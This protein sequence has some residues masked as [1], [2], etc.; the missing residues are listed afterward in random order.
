MKYCQCN[1]GHHDHWPFED[2][3]YDLVVGEFARETALK[4]GNAIHAADEDCYS[5]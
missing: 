2:H 5:G 1:H 3:K 4:F